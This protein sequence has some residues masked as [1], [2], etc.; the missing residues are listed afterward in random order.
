MLPG[1]MSIAN[2]QIIKRAQPC[3]LGF[4]FDWLHLTKNSLFFVSPVPA[5]YNEG[6]E[7]MHITHACA[8]ACTCA[9]THLCACFENVSACK[10]NLHVSAQCIQIFMSISIHTVV[11]T[12]IHLC[13]HAC[14]CTHA[15]SPASVQVCTARH[16]RLSQQAKICWV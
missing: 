6:I 9:C 12:S 7:Q 10:R 15:G 14:T 8:H 5:R 13:A 16:R 3:R 2:P 11:H 1:Q 4:T